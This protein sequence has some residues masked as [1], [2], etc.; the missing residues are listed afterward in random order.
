M[1]GKCI[2]GS[3]IVSLNDT[4]CCNAQLF[5]ALLQAKFPSPDN[6]HLHRDAMLYINHADVH[7][8]SLD[9]DGALVVEA[10]PGSTITIDGLYIHNQGW[11]WQP[12]KEGNG[13]AEHERIRCVM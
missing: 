10:Q 12:L 3:A 1:S 7:V 11:E 9:L 13:S 4:P 2:L 6:V 8:Q 5:H